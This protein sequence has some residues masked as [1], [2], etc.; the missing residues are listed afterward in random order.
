MTIFSIWYYRYRKHDLL[1]LTNCL[2][3]VLIVVTTLMA[4]LLP[5]NEVFSWLILALV[6]IGQATLATKWLL[7][8]A[9]KW[10]LEAQ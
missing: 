7:Q 5:D 2:L 1:L 4:Q 6:I 8:T 10:Q 9:N 3:G